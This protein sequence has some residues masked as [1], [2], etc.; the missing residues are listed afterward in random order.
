MF[1]S[2]AW[3]TQVM[4]T[5]FTVK[6]NYIREGKLYHGDL[7]QLWREP[8]YPEVIHNSLIKTLKNFDVLFPLE[9]V[10]RP[11]RNA[12]EEVS[13]VPSVL[14][15][16]RPPAVKER[17]KPLAP[18][19]ITME[20]NR[21]YVFKFLPYGFFPRLIVRYSPTFL[22]IACLLGVFKYS[23]R[24]A[25]CINRKS[26]FVLLLRLSFLGRCT[27]SSSRRWPT[28]APAC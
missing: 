26:V 28:G 13:L 25:V 8:L 27:C 20:W 22:S 24:C 2:S 10:T 19:E 5:L 4:A 7:A 21:V 17:W 11:G 3:L 14:P 16:T 1:L 6:H 23:Q 12:P 9:C 15:D 18:Q